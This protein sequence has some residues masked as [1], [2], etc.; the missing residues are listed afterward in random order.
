MKI[1]ETVA[2]AMK[3]DP[4]TCCNIDTKNLPELYNCLYSAISDDLSDHNPMEEVKI[5]SLSFPYDAW[6]NASNFI[7]RLYE[8]NMYS[9]FKPQYT[10]CPPLTSLVRNGIPRRIFEILSDKGINNLKSAK[11][12]AMLALYVAFEKYLQPLSKYTNLK[13]RIC[14][15]TINCRTNDDFEYDPF[16]VIDVEFGEAQQPEDDIVYNNMKNIYGT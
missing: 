13:Y 3:L 7:L 15:L 8:H 16:V 2:E 6:G 5:S 4:I 12:A 11:D 14:C 10:G 1:E 9:L